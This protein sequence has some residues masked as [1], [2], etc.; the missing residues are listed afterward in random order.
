MKFNDKQNNQNHV[1][2]F[3]QVVN[4]SIENNK[5]EL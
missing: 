5:F 1:Q 3:Y 2:F 4:I